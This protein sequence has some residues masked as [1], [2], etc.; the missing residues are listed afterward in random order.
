MNSVDFHGGRRLYYQ[1]PF[2]IHRESGFALK[3]DPAQAD[4]RGR[5]C[6]ALLFGDLADLFGNFIDDLSHY[7][8]APRG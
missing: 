2:R 5:G 8:I 1:H 7:P 3:I 6:R 4:L